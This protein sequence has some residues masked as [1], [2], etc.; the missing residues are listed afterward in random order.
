MRVGV[1]THYY[2][3]PHACV[4]RLDEGGLRAGDMVHIRGH[5]TDHYQQVDRLE[6]EHRELEAANPGQDVAMHV[7][8]RVR[9]GDV[10]YRLTS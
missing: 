8:Q 7:S 3:Q 10:V 2:D 5:T 1:V 4:V 9:E 6:W